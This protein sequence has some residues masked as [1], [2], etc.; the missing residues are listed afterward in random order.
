MLFTGQFIWAFQRFPQDLANGK[1]AFAKCSMVFWAGISM[2][3]I[4][5]FSAV[6]VSQVTDATAAFSKIGRN[7]IVGN[8]IISF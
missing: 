6:E 5:V 3:I 7:D 4:W 1:L 2:V 8:G